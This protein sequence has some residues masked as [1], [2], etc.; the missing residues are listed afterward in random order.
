LGL[1][2][3]ELKI[4]LQGSDGRKLRKGQTEFFEDGEGGAAAVGHGFDHGGWAADSIAAAVNPIE[5]GLARLRIHQKPS[6]RVENEAASVVKADLRPLTHGNDHRIRGNPELR[7]WD[8]NGP[9]ASIWPRLAKHIP[10]AQNSRNLPSPSQDAHGACQLQKLVPFS[11]EFFYLLGV[12]GHFRAASAVDHG[13]G[14][15]REAPGGAGRIHGGV[16]STDHHRLFAE[17]HLSSPKET[18]EFQSSKNTRA[19]LSG[20]PKLRLLRKT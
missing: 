12:S 1:F 15:F 20:D 14:V 13:D 6:I 16:P 4:P 11:K 8:G 17:F 19:F 10:H 18:E 3:L 5:I 7:T 2:P 9:A